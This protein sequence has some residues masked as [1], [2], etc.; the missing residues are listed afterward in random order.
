MVLNIELGK[1]QELSQLCAFL[2]CNVPG[3][4]TAAA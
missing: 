2:E 4:V 3:G 1:I